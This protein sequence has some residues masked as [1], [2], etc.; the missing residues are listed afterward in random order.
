MNPEKWRKIK[1]NFN[2]A[3]DLPLAE[4]ES[5]LASFSDSDMAADVRKLLAAD[6]K[7][8]FAN[9]IAGVAHLWREEDEEATE[10][11]GEEI[12]GYR[13]LREIGRGGMGM[14]YEARRDAEDFSQTVALKILRRGADSTE[15]LRRFRRERQILASLEH[16]RIARMLDGGRS[17]DGT[18]FLA[19]EFVAGKPVDEFCNDENLNVEQR[20]RL[21]LQICD[22][23]SF[24]HSRLVV[25]RDLKPSNILVTGDC[26]V[27]LLDFGISKIL[28]EE[29]NTNNRTITQFAMMTPQY[30]SPEQIKG[31]PITTASDIYTLGL[32]LY[33]LLTGVRAYSFPTHHAAEL[34]KIISESEPVRPSSV[35]RDANRWSVENKNSTKRNEERTK[36]DGPKTNLKS[37][38]LNPKSLRGDLDTIVLKA[39]RKEPSRRYSSVEQFA[40]DIERHLDGLPVIARPDTFSYRME[41]FVKRNRVY[42]MTGALIFFTLAGGIAIA[43]WQAR[44]AR[45]QQRAAEKRF[46]QVRELANNI[47]FKY[48]D[49]AEKFPNSTAM[50]QMFVDDSL[51]YFNSLAQE[52]DTDDALRSELARTF[53]R[54]GRVQGAPSS[55]N[56]GRTAE[57]IENYRK[58]IDLLEPIIGKS[59]D[60]TLRGDLVRAYAD[61][62][63]VL[64][65][66]GNQAEGEN[67]LRQA[68]ALAEKLSEAARNDEKLFAKIT[69]VYL[70]YGESLPVGIGADESIQ[71]FDKVI[72]RCEQF[73]A[74]QPDNLRAKNYLAVGCE[75]KGNAFLVLARAAREDEDFEAEKKYLDEAG[76]SFE[77]YI[78]IAGNLLLTNS[79]NVIAPALYASAN[80]SQASYF[81]E[82]AEYAGAL[83]NL[84]KS[85]DFYGT[86]LEKD[87]AHIGLKTQV[88][89]IEQRFAVVYF[90]LGE[91]E[92]AERK[93]ARAFELMDKAIEIDPKNF[94]FAKQRVE[95]KFN[96]AE[97]FLR[98]KDTKK[99][100]RLYEKAFV[101]FFEIAKT[102]NP[103][104]AQ[105]AQAN[106]LEKLGNCFLRENSTQNAIAEYRKAA[107]IWRKTTPLNLSGTVQKDKPLILEKKISRLRLL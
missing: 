68:I 31:E 10:Q 67:A 56:L 85:L 87:N 3:M 6:E 60:T 37:Q 95:M 92:K 102:V 106:Y 78:E 104:Y 49:E 58:G 103:E 62:A 98:R 74:L 29:E 88:A 4:R 107:E 100:R 55:P 17:A 84:Q 86:Q 21:F 96:Y 45:Q 16:P 24:A 77:R 50:R 11:I 8:N 30:A 46:N 53:L 94:D 36:D 90:R 20:L 54:I 9:P 28:S 18:P 101:E 97:E 47:V 23:V 81:T 44:R 64:R 1:E 57:A 26:A 42:V 75:N 91:I 2:R 34:A 66:S 19:M 99:A 33:E 89:D 27:K 51:S 25:H 63:V 32:I 76:K 105:S 41:K 71:A 59:E 72:D 14:V 39:L 79:G 93:F 5:F 73:L 70:F 43:G 38:S 35:V 7:N 61:Y 40:G 15:L 80:V 12:G 69:P 52:A 22:A 82:T 65:Q 48:Y 13:I 83:R